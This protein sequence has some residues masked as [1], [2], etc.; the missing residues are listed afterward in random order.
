MRGVAIV[1]IAAVGSAAIGCQSNP[2]ACGGFCGE[3]T[4]CEAGRCIVAPLPEPEVEAEPEAKGGK[5]RRRKGK[6]KGGR[7]AAGGLDDRDGHIPRY[8]AKRDEQIPE[9][10]ERL[11]DRKVRQQMRTLEPAFN[12]CLER[13]SQ[14]TDATLTGSVSF[15]VGIEPSGKV[16]G[17][18]A[19]LPSKWGVEGLR[20]CFRKVVYGHRFPSWDG[21]SMGVD[22]HFQVD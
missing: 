7:T 18:N 2:A 9:G 8:R 14:V 10:S 4:V 5:K 12:R 22:Y 11:S 21:P 19:R 1:F 16:W 13:A 6:R 15:T 20:A 3:G 17:V